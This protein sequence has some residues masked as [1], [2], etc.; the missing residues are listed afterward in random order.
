MCDDPTG[1]T[2]RRREENRRRLRQLTI[3]VSEISRQVRIIKELLES[4]IMERKRQE[5]ETEESYEKVEKTAFW[6]G[7]WS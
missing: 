4:E 5:R 1:F 3:E 7:F 2:E 6:D